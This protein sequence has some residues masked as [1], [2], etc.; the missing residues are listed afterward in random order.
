VPLEEVQ[1]AVA[2]ADA[3]L[4]AKTRA[5][6]RKACAA[7]S[8]DAPFLAFPFLRDRER[9][10]KNLWEESPCV[11]AKPQRNGDRSLRSAKLIS[12]QAIASSC[13]LVARSFPLQTT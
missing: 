1:R 13:A 7:R 2:M 5:A 10:K 11:T 4:K 8:R 3:A 6:E 12:F 9:N